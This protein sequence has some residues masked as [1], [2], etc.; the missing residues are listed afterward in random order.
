MSD[1]PVQRWSPYCPVP[2]C[3][4][5]SYLRSYREKHE[6]KPHTRCSCGWVGVYY[7]MHVSS[8]RRV[9]PIKEHVEVGL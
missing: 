8:A 3:K 9:D 5:K 6:A 4:T 7:R 2:G 1:R